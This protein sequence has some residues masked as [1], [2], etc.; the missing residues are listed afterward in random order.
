MIWGGRGT[1]VAWGMEIALVQ[2]SD[3]G[4]EV[5]VHLHIPEREES[6]LCTGEDS[7]CRTWALSSWSSEG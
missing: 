6:H 3:G 1:E 7:Q 2:D 4:R 5:P